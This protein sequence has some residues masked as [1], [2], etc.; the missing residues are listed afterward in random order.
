MVFVIA[1]KLCNVKKY[2]S[3]AIQL[4]IQMSFPQMKPYNLSTVSYISEFY[5]LVSKSF[6]NKYHIKVPNGCI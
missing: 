3:C 5:Y 4:R 2:V 6:M 1:S